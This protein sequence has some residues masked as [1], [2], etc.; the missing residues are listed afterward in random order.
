MHSFFY[1]RSP[2]GERHHK[3]TS[4]MIDNHFFYP[5][6]PC[7]ERHT[8]SAAC[9]PTGIFLST[10]PMR[11]ATVKSLARICAGLFL[12]TL[13]MR[14]AT[15]SRHPYNLRIIYFYPRSPCG[16]RQQD[17]QT[18][19]EKHNYFYPRSP[20]G[21]RPVTNPGSP[22]KDEISIH[23]PHAG[24]DGQDFSFSN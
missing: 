19:G 24:S 18:V 17:Q 3:S 12:S 20:C 23:A 8:Y 11:G 21:E 13:P 14:G 10:L 9:V 5:R 1:P 2:C 22:F 4:T 16:E 15:E 7:G 6:S